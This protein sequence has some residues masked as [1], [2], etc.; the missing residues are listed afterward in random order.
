MKVTLTDF[1]GIKPIIALTLEAAGVKSVY[2]GFGNVFLEAEQEKQTLTMHTTDGEVQVEARIPCDCAE[3]GKAIIRVES[4]KKIFQKAEFS[5][6]ELEK[7]QEH[8]IVKTDFGKF[9]LRTYTE[10]DFP[11]K[12]ELKEEITFSVNPTDLLDAIRKTQFSVSTERT[13]YALNGVFIKQRDGKSIEFVATDGRRLSL[14]VCP[15]S[16]MKG[17][18]AN[19]VILPIRF[20]RLIERACG[21][22][23]DALVMCV[24]VNSSSIGWS[25]GKITTRNL[26]GQ[27]PDYESVIPTDNDKIVTVSRSALIQGI[28][29]GSLL[30]EKEAR[31][32]ILEISE[33]HMCLSSH[34]YEG[35]EAEHHLTVDYKG[36]DF[37]IGFNPD[38][39]IEP[40]RVCNSDYV[41]LCFRD[42]ESAALLLS[43]DEPHF[44]YVIMPL[45]VD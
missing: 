19:G 3:E 37:K 6:L 38:Y 39:L 36:P 11:E 28:T 7:I 42:K 43:E 27:F 5:M 40:L 9:R 2:P 4:F 35:E 34:S 21:L 20:V 22:E 31:A 23:T 41:K 30:S 33:N 8:L 18:L 15:V 10:E 12:I 17:E 13:R 45:T 32:V 29:E 1:E 26:E 14:A 16:E 25:D 44:K 24:G